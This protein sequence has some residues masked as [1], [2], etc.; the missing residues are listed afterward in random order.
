MFTRW[1]PFEEGGGWWRLFIIMLLTSVTQAGFAIAANAPFGEQ[2]LDNVASV[3]DVNLSGLMT[4]T[5]AV[6]KYSIMQHHPTGTILNIS[7]ITGHQAPVREFFEA[8][9]HT[10]KAG[11][12]GFTNVLRHELVGTN[13][14]VLLNRPGTRKKG[15]PCPPTRIRQRQN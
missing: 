15:V 12:E 14:R 5:H 4:I 8:S 10:S 13:I 9:Y 7:S 1:T 3:M 6:L 11:V 2:D